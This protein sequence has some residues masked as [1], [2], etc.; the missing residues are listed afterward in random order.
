M[1]R[2]M[3]IVAA[4]VAASAVAIG[5]QPRT[6]RWSTEKANEWMAQQGWIVGCDYVPSNAVNQVEMWQASTFSPELID[7]EMALAESL[8]FNTVRIFLSRAVY[9]DD[10]QGFKQRFT[11]FLEIADRHKIKALVTFWTN[12]GT[13]HRETLGE[14]PTPVKGV[15]NSL[16]CA[17]PGPDYVLDPSKWGE[18]E[19]M[20]K[21]ILT[22]YKD[23]DRIRLWCLYNEPENHSKGVTSSVSF[24]TE[25]FRWAW[26]VNPSQ[27]LTAP[28]WKPIGH[29]NTH[30]PEVSFMLENCDVISFHSYEKPD[31]LQKLI[32]QLKPYGRPM[33]CTEYMGRTLG[34]TFEGAMPI[35]KENNIGAIS[36]GLVAGDLNC[37]YH[38][39]EWK[40]GKIVPWDEEPEVWFHDIFRRD[41]TPYSEDE[42]KFIRSM[43]GVAK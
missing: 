27:P 21:D 13:L 8:G 20:V 40:D 25:T 30:M 11:R 19:R 2:I 14:Q 38:W 39:N 36:W 26:E 15:H 35:F 9:F 6:G 34:S 23:D 37:H 16:W 18:L 10:P 5:A 31:L 22:T 4:V 33:I 7:H 12:G 29:A 17:C 41:G 32:D 42:V 43:T 24:M 3:W 1:K 28:I